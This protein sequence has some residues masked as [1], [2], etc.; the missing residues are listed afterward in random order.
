MR[1]INKIFIHITDTSPRASVNAILTYAHTPV[2]NARTGA[3]YPYIPNVQGGLGWINPPYHY[4]IDGEGCRHHTHPHH[5]VANGVRGHNADAIHVSFIGRLDPNGRLGTTMNLLQESELKLTIIEL[6][7]EYPHA[8][9]L[10]HRDVLKP[11]APG[12]KACP[13]FDV[14]PWLNTFLHNN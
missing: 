14:K 6:H 11:G 13:G 5:R 8:D 9:I 7:R 3:T 10:G 2:R 4:T 1:Q 12:W